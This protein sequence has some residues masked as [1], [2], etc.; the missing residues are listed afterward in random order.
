MKLGL[1]IGTYICSYFKS[2]MKDCE[3][4][5]VLGEVCKCGVNGECPSSYDGVACLVFGKDK[6]CLEVV[7]S[8]QAVLKGCASDLGVDSSVSLITYGTC[9]DDQPLC[10][11]TGR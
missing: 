8:G 4:N 9:V 5:V 1:S 7:T 10:T 6:W 11:G 2:K 3:L